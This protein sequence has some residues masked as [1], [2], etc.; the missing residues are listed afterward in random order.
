MEII[1]R[2][3]VKADAELIAD[4]SRQ[5]FYETFAA[6]NKKEDMDKFFNE[7]FTRGKL[8]MEVGRPGLTFYLAYV[9][10]EV[11]GYLKLREPFPNS[12]TLPSVE[13]ARIYALKKFIGH[14]VGKALMQKS[15]EFARQK[16]KKRIWLGV[17]EKNDRAIKFYQQW[18]FEKFSEHNFLLGNDL[19]TDWLMVKNLETE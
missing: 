11:A 3:A 2:E 13:I 1:L 14:G 6:D 15:I 4:I 17:W 18:G 10:N 8:M 9:G 7:Q 19:Q 5:T 12:K 16:N